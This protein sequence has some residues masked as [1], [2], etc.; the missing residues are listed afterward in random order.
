MEDG[1]KH[2]AT[3]TVVTD[4]KE[5]AWAVAAI[6]ILLYNRRLGCAVTVGP[7]SEVRVKGKGQV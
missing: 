5:E 3:V 1:D 4:S 6:R 7:K 2:V